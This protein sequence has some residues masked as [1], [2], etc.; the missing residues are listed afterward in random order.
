MINLPPQLQSDLAET[1][2]FLHFFLK[3]LKK[4]KAP[5]GVKDISDVKK[6]YLA[7]EKIQP[8]NSKNNS[9]SYVLSY[10]TLKEIIEKIEFIIYYLNKQRE[11]LDNELVDTLVSLKICER[12]IQNYSSD[13]FWQKKYLN[14]Q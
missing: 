8:N 4:S 6:G 2:S 12:V 14:Y 9:D 10:D 3:D 11:T 5:S 13:A 1:K 7:L